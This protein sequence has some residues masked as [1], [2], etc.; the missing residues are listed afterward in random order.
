M[1]GKLTQGE[2]SAQFVFPE[3]DSSNSG[4]ELV[5]AANVHW[6]AALS[7]PGCP[8][9]NLAC[10]RG[11]MRSF[12]PSASTGPLRGASV[13]HLRPA[14]LCGRLDAQRARGS[15]ENDDLT[16]AS[17]PVKEPYIV[18]STPILQTRQV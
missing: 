14:T 1:A 6:C 7:G 10:G 9:P 5:P 2:V 11:G 15:S 18:G 4:C 17:R 13:R 8:R 16:R 12:C 3:R